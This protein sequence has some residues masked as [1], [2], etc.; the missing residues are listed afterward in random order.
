MTEM[1]ARERVAFEI[2]L[3]KEK[4]IDPRTAQAGRIA[5]TFATGVKAVQQQVAE[6]RGGRRAPKGQRAPRIA[7]SQG[8]SDNLGLPYEGMSQRARTPDFGSGTISFG[9]PFNRQKKR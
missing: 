7:A 3:A 5:G 2:A 9:S 1:T 4:Y 6:E 8:S